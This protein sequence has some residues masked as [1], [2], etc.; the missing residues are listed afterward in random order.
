MGTTS[1]VRDSGVR[2]GGIDTARSRREMESGAVWLGDARAGR[3]HTPGSALVWQQFYSKVTRPRHGFLRWCP[4][5]DAGEPGEHE[6]FTTGWKLVALQLLRARLRPATTPGRRV[7]RAP[8]AHSRSRSPRPPSG[9]A[10]QRS[11][12]CCVGRA[13]VQDRVPEQAHPERLLERDV[14]D[15]IQ[16]GVLA[17]LGEHAALDAH[18]LRGDLEARG[19]A[20][21][22]VDQPADSEREIAISQRPIEYKA[23]GRP[24]NKVASTAVWRLA[25]NASMSSPQKRHLRA[26]ALMISPHAGQGLVSFMAAD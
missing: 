13:Q 22:P 26:P 8:D 19:E 12:A 15:A 14:V 1:E 3:D 16:L 25:T 17:S 4:S 23:T 20:R 2:V 5:Q 10:V 24:E 9:H 11:R 6:V 21:D 18:A 7:A